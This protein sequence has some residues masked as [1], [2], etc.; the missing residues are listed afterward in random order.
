MTSRKVF[1]VI[2][3]VLGVFVAVWIFR[4]ALSTFWM[5]FWTSLSPRQQD[6]IVSGLAGLLVGVF[7]SM[8]ASYLFSR[9]Q[10]EVWQNDIGALTVQ[11]SNLKDQLSNMGREH[12]VLLRDLVPAIGGHFTESL[13]SFHPMASKKIAGILSGETERL[14]D[15][16]HKRVIVTTAKDTY[17]IKELRRYES[18][19]VWSLEFHI[20]WQW[21]N[22][23]RITKRPLEDLLLAAVANEEALDDFSP[24][25]ESDAQKLAQRR[26]LEGFLEKNLVKSTV[27]NP[28]D[29]SRRIP[30]DRLNEVFTID[31]VDVT[32]EGRPPKLVEK[33]RLRKVPPEKLP[34][35]VYEAYELPPEFNVSLPVDA[36]LH[37]E[38]FGRMCLLATLEEADDKVYQGHMTFSPSDVISDQYELRLSYP[39]HVTL[40]GKRVSLEVRKE[41]SGSQHVHGPLVNHPQDMADA[42][43]YRLAEM[44]VSEALTDLHQLSLRWRGRVQA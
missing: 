33:A 16:H 40:D 32:E 28:L 13:F 1:V 26:E 21:L 27:V 14:Y 15:R 23:S 9:V 22:D 43:G 35:G 20:T 30:D 17:T 12:E 25:H 6:A 8:V 38:Y 24:E 5:R 2:L 18:V 29:A 10:K 7:S 34:I 11:L 41:S 44:K 36:R 42:K 3:I 4:D 37:V 39:P 31:K 19:F